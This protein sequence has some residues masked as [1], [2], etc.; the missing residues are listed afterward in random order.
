M[1]NAT[2]HTPVHHPQV[3]AMVSGPTARSH[4]SL[5]QRPRLLGQEVQRAEGP[6]Q[7]FQHAPNESGLQPSMAGGNADLGR[8]PSLVWP[9]P[10]VR[11]ERV[12]RTCERF[13]EATDAL[14]AANWS[15]VPE[16]PSVAGDQNVVTVEAGSSARFFRLRKL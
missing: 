4:S 10:L 12:H 2:S 15:A 11:P 13:L 9:A 1:S 14:P 8:W 16:T 3:P 7:A 6:V 5:G